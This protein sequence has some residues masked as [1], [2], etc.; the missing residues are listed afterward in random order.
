MSIGILVRGTRFYGRC[1]AHAPRN[2]LWSGRYRPRR[3][4]H[5][6]TKLV[7]SHA[8]PGEGT[9]IP[10]A[11][12]HW[13]RL[14]WMPVSRLQDQDGIRTRFARSKSVILCHDDQIFL[15]KS[16]IQSFPS[17]ASESPYVHARGKQC[18]CLS[19]K[20]HSPRTPTS[21]SLALIC[22]TSGWRMS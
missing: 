4:L 16:S 2:E 13:A 1:F 10:P 22:L 20:S 14:M 19:H 11:L 7:R 5:Q 21:S 17:L 6:D 18:I 12:P 9:Q 15:S 8:R 3:L